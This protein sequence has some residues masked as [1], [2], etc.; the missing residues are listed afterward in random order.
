[1]GF[2]FLMLFASNIFLALALTWLLLALLCLPFSF[3]C[4]CFW[5]ETKIDKHRL[6]FLTC[7]LYPLCFSLSYPSFSCERS[8]VLVC[9]WEVLSPILWLKFQEGGVGQVADLFFDI[10]FSYKPMVF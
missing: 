10:V 2:G 6:D 8:Q 7:L 9:K 5:R 1:M 3:S 4:S